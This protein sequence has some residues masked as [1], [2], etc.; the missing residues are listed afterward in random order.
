MGSGVD[1]GKKGEDWSHFLQMFSVL[2]PICRI[3]SQAW[4]QGPRP[5][6]WGSLKHALP[7][8][9]SSLLCRGSFPLQRR[10]YLWIGTLYPSSVCS[11]VAVCV[12]SRTELLWLETGLYFWS[13]RSL[14]GKLGIFCAATF[15]PLWGWVFFIGWWLWEGWVLREGQSPVVCFP[16]W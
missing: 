9:R 15:S 8:R 2:S 5:A 3:L 14:E 4:L 6:S 16:N 10:I 12:G 7:L 11:P 1:K 13:V